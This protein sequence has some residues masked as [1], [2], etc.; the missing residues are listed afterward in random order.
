MTRESKETIARRVDSLLDGVHRLEPDPLP[1]D[2]R[3]WIGFELGL[4]FWTLDLKRVLER[5]LALLEE[6]AERGLDGGV[7]PLEDAFTRIDQASEK[8]RSILVQ[9]LGI[10]G[11]V[12]QK[13]RLE[14]RPDAKEPRA[15]LAK[16]LKT[17]ASTSP[18]ANI[19]LANV[20]EL[21]DV[22]RVRDDLAHG[23]VFVKNT[24][25]VGYRAML[26][27]ESSSVIGQ[28]YEYLPPP[29]AFAMP[30]IEERTRFATALAMG[31]AA[32]KTVLDAVEHT[33]EVIEEAGQ[34][35]EPTD[36][37][38]RIVDDRYVYSLTEPRK[39]ETS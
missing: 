11:L 9:A 1:E 17:L 26:V 20:R 12:M 29:F 15:F 14:Y 24:Y 8:L 2:D 30:D 39:E 13:G 36:V 21:D 34:Y 33:T 19:L 6:A 3:G 27:D 35:R 37:Y 38:V 31:A 25:V 28:R 4:R 18:A 32:L 10:D 22:R 16:R 23:L 7:E 5:A